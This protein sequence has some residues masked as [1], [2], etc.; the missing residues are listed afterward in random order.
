M[1]IASYE[2]ILRLCVQPGHH[3]ADRIDALVTFCRLARIDEVMFFINCEELNQG[4][5]T[6]AE[7]EAWLDVAR[8]ARPRLAKIGVRTSLNPWQ[9]ILHFDNGRQFKPS[10]R[11]TAMV[12]PSGRAA[13]AQACPLCPAWQRYLIES[14]A[15]YAA[16]KPHTVWVEDDFRLHNHAPLQWGGCFCDRHVKMFAAKIGRSVRRAEFVK[17]MLQPG[18]PHPWRKIWLDLHRNVWNDLAK[19]IGDAV[20]KVSPR[21][22]IGLMSSVPAVH[23]A[24][25]RDWHTLLRNLSGGNAV[26]SRPHLPSYTEEP[27]GRYLWLYTMITQATQ[28]SVPPETLFYPEIDNFAASNTRFSKS[29]RFMRFQMLLATGLGTRGMTLNIFDMMG[30]GIH[31][32][33]RYERVLAASKP[34]LDR[35]VALNLHLRD[36]LGVRVLFSPESS[37]S[38]QTAIGAEM[39]E[40]YSRET[41][42]AGLL[43]SHGIANVYAKNMPSESG[44]ASISGQFFRNLSV[45]EIE[46]L[47]ERH[48]LILD[49]EAAATLIDLGLGHLIGARGGRWLSSGTGTFAYEQVTDGRRYAGIAEARISGQGQAGDLF[50]IDYN[51]SVD[52]RSRIKDANGHDAAAGLT[53]IGGRCA[54][55]PYGRTPIWPMP[56][57]T[58]VR[59][60]QLR[61]VLYDIAPAA[62]APTC[63]LDAPYLA[64]QHFRRPDGD[65]ILVAN[66]SLD[67]VPSVELLGSFAARVGTVLDSADAAARWRPVRFINRGGRLIDRRPLRSLDIRIYRLPA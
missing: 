25:G 14:Y 27:P 10:Q 48:A 24:E 17:R 51:D 37:R 50:A 45:A 32:E 58:D 65:V 16:I 52:I 8:R 35:T 18:E 40:L 57:L 3:E 21:T 64:V 56:H 67:D 15:R 38:V 62:D 36:Q 6:H 33:E 5:L 1:P 11:W 20:V 60:E 49:G 44:I 55:L 47:F 39:S 29:H 2:Y 61:Q 28:A 42:W 53:V 23:C 31:A 30:N 4:H 22:R 43:S 54:I 63:T 66:A 19:R 46:A 9:T 7:T 12:D 41:F 13:T 59:Q 26:I 34:F